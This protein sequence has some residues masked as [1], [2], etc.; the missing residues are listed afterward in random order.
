MLDQRKT[1]IEPT[2]TRRLAFDVRW[3][4]GIVSFLN[5]LTMTVTVKTSINYCDAPPSERGIGLITDLC[6]WFRRHRF[7]VCTINF[8]CD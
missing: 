4:T 8:T 6:E 7:Q 1:N 3:H 5:V 2:L